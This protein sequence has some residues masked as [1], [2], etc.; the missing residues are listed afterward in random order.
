VRY[1]NY[2]IICATNWYDFIFNSVHLFEFGLNFIIDIL[3]SNEFVFFNK[4]ILVNWNLLNFFHNLFH[5]DNFLFD[6][7][8]LNYFLFD[9]V[10]INNFLNEFINNFIACNKNWLFGSDLNKFRYLNYFLNNFLYLVDF[11][12]LVNH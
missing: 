1:L 6:C 12:H 11:G 2:S 3:F 8:Y 5:L 10:S 7:R 9:R 4:Y